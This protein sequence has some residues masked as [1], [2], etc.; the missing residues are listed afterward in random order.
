MSCRSVLFGLAWAGVCG[1]A[2][3]AVSAA[4]A[5]TCSVAWGVYVD[6]TPASLD[7]LT[8][9]EA[10]VAR[11]AAI[12]HWYQ[13]WQP[14]D[15][16][17][18]E[19]KQLQAVRDHGAWP[20]I[21]WEPRGVPLADITGG[22]RDDYIDRWAA[23]LADYGD[24]VLLAPLAGVDD[25]THSYA[26]SP[27]GNT[28][29][30][31]VAAWRHVHDRVVADGTTNVLWVFD[32]MGGAAAPLEQLYPGDPEVDWFGMHAYNGGG[33]LGQ[34]WASLADLVS[35]VYQRL[36]AISADK[37]MMLSEFGSVEE[38]GDKPHWLQ[39][40]GSDIAT[41]F[42][43]VKAAIYFDAVEPQ[44]SSID[45]RLDTTPASLAAARAAFKEGS[46]YCL[47][48]AGLAGDSQATAGLP[49]PLRRTLS[50][51]IPLLGLTVLFGLGIA[52]SKLPR[53]KRAAPGPAESPTESK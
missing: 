16:P 47:T 4:D 52:F 30:D 22:Q 49:G 1:L 12:V 31:V 39:D 6:G 2:P 37:P 35:P 53:P 19:K 40:A 50:L 15:N 34:P 11:Q 3:L 24:P 8:G 51:A 10:G 42:P 29:D 43:Q 32:V 33:A 14:D 36:Q 45:W 20:F 5:P 23:T 48:A 21:S 25:P 41:R 27:D 9:V 18:L 7:P 38:G 13:G 46:A 28:A 26:W 17:T 44:R